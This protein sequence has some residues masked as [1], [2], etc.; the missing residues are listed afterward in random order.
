[1][2][3]PGFG[4]QWLRDALAQA[5]HG[6]AE[7]LLQGVQGGDLGTQQVGNGL[8]GIGIT[9]VGELGH[10]RQHAVGGVP[11]FEDF[12]GQGLL[13]LA[14][15]H[16]Q[17]AVA[18]F[19]FGV[20]GIRLAVEE[21]VFVSRQAAHD[22]TGFAQGFGVDR[23]VTVDQLLDLT[24]DQV[25]LVGPELHL[26]G[27]VAFSQRADQQRL[28]LC[29]GFLRVEEV[30]AGS[31]KVRLAF[32]EGQGTDGQLAVGFDPAAVGRQ[33]HLFG[34]RCRSHRLRVLRRAGAEGEGGK[35]GE[36]QFGTEHARLLCLK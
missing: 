23:L 7:L 31:G 24:A 12:F 25:F 30:G 18:G 11:A 16:Q 17:R 26:P 28:Q 6:C 33:D 27:A 3:A 21:D 5:A 20:G 1:M 22:D 4:L 2:A 8:V 19:L 32:A 29:P 15:G 36:Q 9:L 35:A 10:L 14:D 13:V 34:D